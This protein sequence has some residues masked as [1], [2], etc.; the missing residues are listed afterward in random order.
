MIKL[1]IFTAHKNTFQIAS[2]LVVG[3]KFLERA[4]IP[5]REST[6]PERLLEAALGF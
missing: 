4:D 5:V 3:T 6:Q 1:R 2:S